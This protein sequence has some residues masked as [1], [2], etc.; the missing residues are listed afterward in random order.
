MAHQVDYTS[1]H[2][3]MLSTQTDKNRVSAP[4][5][6][7]YLQKP[8]VPHSC[9]SI[10]RVV[11]LWSLSLSLILPLVMSV[12]HFSSLLVY[13]YISRL[14]PSS[15]LPSNSLSL[16]CPL[17]LIWSTLQ[18]SLFRFYFTCDRLILF[19]VMHIKLC[20]FTEDSKGIKRKVV[21][22]KKHCS[23]MIETCV[24]MYI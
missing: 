7:L 8:Y 6:Y 1:A 5:D 16:M 23:P 20:L 2:L 21:A 19:G 24:I 10:F 18:S 11:L 22:L 9:L 17:S 13:P 15:L 3:C 4:G 12:S 14:S